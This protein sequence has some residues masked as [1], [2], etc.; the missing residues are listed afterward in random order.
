[1]NDCVLTPIIVALF[2]NSNIDKI[3]VIYDLPYVEGHYAIFRYVFYRPL[4]YRWG[5]SEKPLWSLSETRRTQ[6]I[7][8]KFV[9]KKEHLIRTNKELNSPY[10]KPSKAFFKDMFHKME[11]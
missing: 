2:I 7:A 8:V 5:Q 1:M 9:P 3:Y 10:S 11:L 6:V 4:P